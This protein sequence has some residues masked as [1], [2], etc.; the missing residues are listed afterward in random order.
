MNNPTIQPP[1]AGDE[2][3]FREPWEAHAFA[4]IVSLHERGLFTW[5]EWAEALAAQIGAAQARG[6][7]DRGDP[8]YRHRLAP[9]DEFDS[10]SLGAMLA[11]RETA[12]L[13]K[14]LALAPVQRDILLGLPADTLRALAAGNSATELAVLANAMLE[15]VQSPT[16]AAQLT[17]RLGAATIECVNAQARS[18]YGLLQLRVRGQAKVRCVALWLA[19]AHNLRLWVRHQ[20]PAAPLTRAA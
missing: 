11:V 3:V 8:S 9:P 13:Q 6:D 10:Y 19:L 5:P 14:L 2:P 7:A 18:H 1:G 20:P 4:L 17:Y 15:P 12:D 16:G